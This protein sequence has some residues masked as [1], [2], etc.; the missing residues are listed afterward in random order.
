MF[1]CVCV[2]L[3]NTNYSHI[4]ANLKPHHYFIILY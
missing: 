2:Y 3:A 4:N 1:V